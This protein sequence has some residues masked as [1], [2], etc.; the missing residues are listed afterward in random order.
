MDMTRRGIGLIVAAV[1]MFAGVAAAQDYN[2]FVCTTRSGSTCSAWAPLDNAVEDVAE[3]AAANMQY[4][5]TVRRDTA[6]SSAGTTGDNAT[7]N[8]DSLGRLWVAGSAVEDAAETAGGILVMA[9][10]VQRT[11][12]AASA[13]TTGDN[14]TLNTDANGGLWL[15]ADVIED[16]AETAAAPIVGVGTVRRDVLVSSAGTT[17]DNAT[18]NTSALGSVWT[19]EATRAVAY[20]SSPTAV[21]A[22]VY[23][24]PIADLEGRPYVNASHPRAINCYVST[25]A[26][27]ATQ[28]TGCEVVAAN[29][30]YITSVTVSGDIANAVSTPWQI[31][32]GTSTNCT[33]ATVVLGGYHGTLG[34]VHMTFPTPIKA[35]AAHGLCILDGTTGTKTAMITGYLAP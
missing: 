27:T 18:M 5:G 25:T 14:A 6:A 26:T 2:M 3:T 9:G 32:T 15:A 10:T 30:I 8:T 22:G 12:K 23:G 34:S 17:G 4:C 33:G 28:V 29:S 20:G 24:A 19:E 21:A 1:A 16:V 11:T 13:G 35:T 31:T 7:L